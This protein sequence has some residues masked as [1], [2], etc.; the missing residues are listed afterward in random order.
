MYSNKTTLNPNPSSGAS[1]GPEC[2]PELT[3]YI[4]HYFLT[5]TMKYGHGRVVMQPGHA[6]APPGSRASLTTMACKTSNKSNRGQWST[7]CCV[8]GHGVYLRGLCLD[9]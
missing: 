3:A 9:A 7:E 8:P 1:A 5:L 2:V 6:L 4:I